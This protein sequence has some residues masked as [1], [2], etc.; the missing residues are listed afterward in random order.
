VRLR[1]QEAGVPTIRP[2]RPVSASSAAF[3]IATVIATVILRDFLLHHNSSFP[4]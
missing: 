1:D 4:L 2:K 3:I